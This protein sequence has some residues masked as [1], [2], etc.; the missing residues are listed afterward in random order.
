M[1]LLTHRLIQLICQMEKEIAVRFIGTEETYPLRNLVL[2]PNKPVESVFLERDNDPDSFHL[3]AFIEANV[4]SVGS[5]HRASHQRFV[6][7]H[8]YQLR[9][10]A[11]SPDFRKMNAGR[12]LIEFAFEELK[13]RN[14]ELLWCNA[15]EVAIAFYK[16]LGFE[17]A[18]G[19]FDVPGIG[20]H[21]LMYI[22]LIS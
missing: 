9:K 2:R 12:K 4:I 10:M 17:T 19:F 18:S 21:K 11:T 8:Q 1:V 22:K 6:E 3:G 16:K 13:T 14:T 7:T 5:F 20:P 15:R